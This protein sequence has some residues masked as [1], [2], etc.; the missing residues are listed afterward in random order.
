MTSLH[1]QPLAEGEIRLLTIDTT[2]LSS[3]EIHISMSATQLNETT[4]Y[5]ALSYVW[6][7]ETNL[8]DIKLNGR[9]MSVTAN[10]YDALTCMRKS[11]AVA[12]LGF[13][14]KIWVDAICINQGDISERNKQVT[15][16]RDIYTQ[17]LIVWA[18]VGAETE[19]DQEGFKLMKALALKFQGLSQALDL[20]HKLP[21]DASQTIANSLENPGLEVAWKAMGRLLSRPWWTRAWVVQE[22]ALARSA[23]FGCGEQAIDMYDVLLVGELLWAYMTQA[24]EQSDER[25]AARITVVD[26]FEG[27]DVGS[28]DASLLSLQNRIQRLDRKLQGMDQQ[29]LAQA[30]QH[31]GVRDAQKRAA[32]LTWTE[33]ADFCLLSTRKIPGHTLTNVLARFKSRQCGNPLDKIYALLGLARPL[34]EPS[35]LPVDYS[36]PVPVLWRRAVRAHLQLYKNLDILY[37]FSGLPTPKDFSSWAHEFTARWATHPGNLE[38][39]NEGV[40]FMASLGRSPQFGHQASDYHAG[41]EDEAGKERLMEESSCLCLNGVAVD[42]VKT[43]GQA[44]DPNDPSHIDSIRTEIEWQ[45][46]LQ[47][48]SEAHFHGLDGPALEQW[49][50]LAGV[51]EP[52]NQVKGTA[53]SLYRDQDNDVAVGSKSDQNDL[54]IAVW[55]S[56]ISSG[57]LKKYPTG[58]TN[59]DAFIQTLMMDTVPCQEYAPLFH[60]R[61]A[62]LKGHGRGDPFEPM[63]MSSGLLGS[64]FYV[65]DKGYYGLVPCDVQVGDQVCVLYGSKVPFLLRNISDTKYELLSWTFVLGLM[66]GEALANAS[67]R[68]LSEKTFCLV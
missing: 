47:D 37:L 5:I 19:H 14:A 27:L 8:R 48:L 10:L 58:Q 31:L 18:F 24:V 55:S 26:H 13:P 22:I 57:M 64:R 12:S 66:N 17:A 38:V 29:T 51:K 1:Y 62:A 6:G 30:A 7:S 43:A 34:M 44:F 45:K 65:T 40:E 67:I 9:S 39:E 52:F 59:L 20:G 61:L 35:I 54:I 49:K 42:T 11:I 68:H 41:E 21:E 33:V 28:R 50:E 3:P 60:Q 53:F 23:I 32:S 16:M 46:S 2:S 15:R 36:L 63:F 25:A 4:E 56:M